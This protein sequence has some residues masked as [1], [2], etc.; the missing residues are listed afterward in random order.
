[1][2]PAPDAQNYG[3]AAVDLGYLTEA[4]VQECVLVQGKMR[5]MG[6][7][8]PLGVILV[9]KGL[10]DSQQNKNV[11]MRLG[12]PTNPF[13]GY[14]LLAKIGQGGMG[15]VYKALQTSVNRPVALKVLAPAFTRDKTYVDRFLQEARAAA[16][17][18]HKNLITAID[19][20]EAGGHFYFVMEY[21]TGK[22]CRDLVQSEG[23]FDEKKALSV[24][25]QMAEVLDHIHRHAMV[26][27][28]IKPE[29]ILLT[30]D[31][32]VKLCDFGLARS[33]AAVEET[34][35]K[36]RVVIGTPRFMSPEQ[37]RGE[38]DLDI[39]SDLYSLGATLFFL[40]TARPPFAGNSAL[41][42]MTQHLNQP[43]PD[44]RRAAPR[45]SENLSL[46]IQK[47]MAKERDERYQRPADLLEDLRAL[48]ARSAP[49][50]AR[51]KGTRV[52]TSQ[53][54]HSTRR[55]T[56]PRPFA[57]RWLVAAAGA[58]VV[59]GAA[60]ILSSGGGDPPP[61]PAPVA[62]PAP[63]RVPAPAGNPEAKRL[64]EQA[65]DLETRARGNPSEVAAARLHWKE[66]EGRFQGTPDYPQFAAA[67]LDFERVVEREA[68]VVAGRILFDAEASVR[69][70]RPAE[71]IRTIRGFPTGFER[72]VAA[73]RVA[74][75][76]A[77]IARELENRYRL[78]KQACADLV[79]AE[80]FDDA[81]KQ[82]QELRML[83]SLSGN[84]TPDPFQ[85]RF[86]EELDSLSRTLEE[87][88]VL[89]RGRLA[90][91][92][93]RKPPSPPPAPVPAAA[94]PP[95]PEPEPREQPPPPPPPQP[96]ETAKPA[97]P[98][99]TAQK[100][101]EKLIRETFKLDYAKRQPAD[102]QALA[103]KLLKEGLDE[104]NGP[105]D[106]FV[107]LR[108]AR[109]LAAPAG[110]LD[111]A[112]TAIDAMSGAFS[113]DALG[114]KVSAVAK[115]PPPKAADAAR[116][117]AGRCLDILDEALAAD[118][119]EIAGS[120]ASKAEPAAKAAQDPSLWSRAQAKSRDA[121]EFQRQY[122]RLRPLE[123]TL[124][125][126]P[127]D[128]A[129][130]LE[131]G[132]F[133]CL[134]KGDWSKGLPYLSRGSD[135]RLKELA[136]KD[137]A[138]PAGAA[139]QTE[140]GDGWFE[141]AAAERV[142]AAK[143]R[144]HERALFWYEKAFPEL[145]GMARAKV[146]KRIEGLLPGKDV[147]RNGLVFWVE[148]SRT[149]ADATRDLIS[150]A[151]PA[152]NDSSVTTDSGVKV[153]SFSGSTLQYAASD[154]VKAIERRGSVFTWV[155]G[156][157]YEGWAILASRTGASGG[158][159]E[160][161]TGGNGVAWYMYLDAANYPAYQAKA[162]LT[163]GTWT[164]LGA[165]WNDKTLRLY[166][167]GREDST[168]SMESAPPKRSGVLSVGVSFEGL[169]G[170]VLIYNRDVSAQ[171]ALHIF[172]AGRGKFK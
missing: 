65:K 123:K 79:A 1:M 67:L 99:A 119:Y 133:H 44:P 10:L 57:V 165:S 80:R 92:E 109:D 6:I 36:E 71:A 153:L 13:P 125:E 22:S 127:N 81:R 159:F 112:L 96:A 117:L 145:S 48:E 137:L 95:P 47:L 101:S 15:T 164:L 30:P 122:Q 33:T 156:K 68:E 74:S 128:P 161:W 50:H 19:A 136:R 94:A 9:K 115:V 149:A 157:S 87:A 69:A 116:A 172:T 166:V 7:D 124:N 24:A 54:P 35:T 151:K 130:N 84:G 49:R 106:R 39:R 132:R 118:R 113:V 158:D 108:E 139:A 3:R 78:G 138:G 62:R 154:A 105:V 97:A 82:L 98:N 41:E 12:I 27:R 86:R 104:Q 143:A 126:N 11:L 40:A 31:G 23:A 25:I 70:G 131:L 168:V 4:Q 134:L 89:A 5:E 167:D 34:E 52:L 16:K 21:V 148:P 60:L 66:L 170:S 64:L 46:V 107:L 73:T 77:D 150:G 121:S 146:E 83:V 152:V 103:R 45:L 51:G 100:A 61:A 171:D 56:A 111:T 55:L 72:T 91:A 2:L 102:Q 90:E 114:M 160:L 14:T 53:K 120:L 135:E 144:F 110:D 141:G 37:I 42:T 155:K 147:P 59:G 142:P 85:G 93:A 18:S 169:V 20:G 162:A 58:A 63:A 17:L 28:D 26:H 140:M 29:N 75:R 8:E 88:S 38:R 43:V 32:G 76:S 163:P 129:A